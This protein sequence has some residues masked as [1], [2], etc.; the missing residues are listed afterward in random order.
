MGRQEIYI[1]DR[2]AKYVFRR[3]IEQKIENKTNCKN[4]YQQNIKNDDYLY[5]RN[6]NNYRIPVRMNKNKSV[7]YILINGSIKKQNNI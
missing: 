1:E 2:Y 6:P 7:I 4:N 3:Q 5:G